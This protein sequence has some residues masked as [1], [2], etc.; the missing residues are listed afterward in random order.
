VRVPMKVDV[1]RDRTSLAREVDGRIENVYRLQVM[2]TEERARRVTLAVE[3][4][5]ALGALEILAP[6]PLDVAPAQALTVPVR[7]RAEPSGK[8]GSQPI[9]F[10][11]TSSDPQARAFAI[12]EKSRFLMP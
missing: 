6:T 8:R 11:I 1:I 5:A 3:G 4:P 9:E 12:R 7:V 10:V 2:N